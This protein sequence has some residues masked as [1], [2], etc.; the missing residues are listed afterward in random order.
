MR[1]Q[2]AALPVLY[3]APEEDSCRSLFV[4]G[5]ADWIDIRCMAGE[6]GLVSILLVRRK[7][8]WVRVRGKR[9]GWVD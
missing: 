2:D 8:R 3:N 4:E 7:R 5:R 1:M 9:Y 6:S